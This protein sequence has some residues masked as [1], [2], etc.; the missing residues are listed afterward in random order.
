MT[1]LMESYAGGLAVLSEDY[2]KWRALVI[3]GQIMAVAGIIIITAGVIIRVKS[4]MKGTSNL[5]ILKERYAKGE[6]IKE[7]F[8]KMKEDLS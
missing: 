1:I 7:E 4:K 5:D 3:L 8:D 6:I 2:Q